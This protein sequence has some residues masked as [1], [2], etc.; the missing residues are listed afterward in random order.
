MEVNM[1]ISIFTGNHVWVQIIISPDIPNMDVMSEAKAKWWMF[2]S[3]LVTRKRD[4]VTS[5]QPS[6][7]NL[8]EEKHQRPKIACHARDEEFQGWERLIARSHQKAD[9]THLLTGMSPH[10]TAYR[11]S[12]V[13]LS[14]KVK[15]SND[16]CLDGHNWGKQANF[17][18]GKIRR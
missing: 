11:E 14:W 6:H 5:Y 9:I 8:Q 3:I 12:M 1:R 2:C 15:V 16:I 18:S 7:A 17:S 13:H 10:N 4:S